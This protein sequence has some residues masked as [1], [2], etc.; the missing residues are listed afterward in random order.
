MNDFSNAIKNKII[1]NYEQV[2]IIDVIDDK[3]YKYVN[4]NNNFNLLE[5]TSYVEYFSNCKNFIF[6][7]DI[8]NYM[9][10]LSITKLE[11]NNGKITLNYRM[12]DDKIGTYMNYINIVSLY[13]E[14]DKKMIIV[15]V[16]RD[17]SNTKI[18]GLNNNKVG[19]ESKLNK[20]IDSVSMAMLKIHN[21]INMDN[22]LR[23]KDEYVNSIL[24]EL[25]RGY[26]EL[27]KSLNE[28]AAEIYNNGKTTILIVDDDKMTCNLI[29]KVFDKHYDILIANNGRE[30]IDT[31]TSAKSNNINISCI[32]LDLI[33]P[34]LDGF[35]VLEFLND[36]NY[37]MRLPVVI[38]SGNYDKETRNRAY[39]YQIADMLEKP[40]NAQVIRHRI[41]NLISLYRS[42]GILNELLLEQQQDAKK[43]ID[44]LVL[45]YEIDNSYKMS[46]IKKYVKILTTQIS[47]QYPEYNINSNIIDK[48]ANSSAYYDIGS[49]T[50]PRSILN[51][52]S[53][54]TEEEK[55]IINMENNN[56][57]A[58]VKIVLANDNNK[59]DPQYC[60]E[61]TKYYHERYDGRGYPEGLN[62]NNIPLSASI[63]GLVVEYMNLL[64]NFTSIDYEKI[65]SLIIME[66]GHK[67]S[68]KVVEAFKNVKDQFAIVS[69]VGE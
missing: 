40:F 27:N 35:S 22:N 25:V 31:L 57:A 4:S 12:L 32:F 24:A 66:S 60:Y 69:K 51:K 7:D 20:L 8:S 36:N 52:K 10:S 47:V 61:I 21:V 30:A 68:P 2:L 13:E 26:P 49:Y 33:M 53:E 42:S 67:F 14:N 16:C 38:I 23:T 34:E 37:L 1:E 15:L 46:M 39:S 6:E 28:N 50:L 18:E 19:L 63:V 11:N 9:D 65:A 17:D 5:E 56:A 64:N 41:E 45:S 58:I 55:K 43:I 48:I 44:S 3:I 59:V 62:G 54:Y 29:S